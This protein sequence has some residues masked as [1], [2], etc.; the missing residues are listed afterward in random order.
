MLTPVTVTFVFIFAFTYGRVLLYNTENDQTVE[1][2]DCVYYK[3]NDGEEISY[4]RRPG[5]T[6]SLDRKQKE[7][8]NQG[9]KKLFRNLI[10]QDVDPSDILKWSSSVEM[11]DIYATVFY[12]RSLI[13]HDNI[14]QIL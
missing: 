3:H 5:G 2:F 8:D 1:K 11:A 7:C 6:E 4:C 14:R 12:N 13:D 10:D 9:E